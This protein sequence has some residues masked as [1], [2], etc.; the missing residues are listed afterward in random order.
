MSASILCRKILFARVW[1][2]FPDLRSQAI[3]SASKRSE[4]AFFTGR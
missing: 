4:T 1:Y 3:T 2:P